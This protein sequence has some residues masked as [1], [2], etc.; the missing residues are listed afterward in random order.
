MSHPIIPAPARFEGDGGEF[1]FRSGTPIAY[2]TIAVA[3]IVERFC[4]EITRRTGL[5]LAPMAGNPGSHEGRAIW[6]Q[7]MH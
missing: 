3:P 6:L 7:D 2:T 1:A 5:R 4:S